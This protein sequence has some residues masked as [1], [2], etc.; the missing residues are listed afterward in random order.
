MN[1]RVLIISYFFPPD[2]GPGTQRVTKFCKYLWRFGWSPT[3]LTRMVPE[4][5]GR[6]DPEDRSL[7]R[8]I[9]SSVRVI[10]VEG[11]DDDEPDWTAHLPVL[12]SPHIM[13]WNEAAFIRARSLLEAEQFDLVLITM[14][15]FD[16]AHL[17]R[18]IQTQL[19][20]PVI[21]DLRDPWALDGWRSH[22]SS[23]HWRRDLSCMRSTLM[24]ADGVIAN[25]P[26][27]KT[28]M[29]RECREITPP[30]LYMIPNGYDE[31]D[32]SDPF[33]PVYQRDPSIFRIVHTGS[34]HSGEL[35]ARRTLKGKLRSWFECSGQLIDPSGRTPFHLLRAL[36]RLQRQGHPLAGRVRVSLIGTIDDATRRCVSESGVKHL[37]ELVDYLPHRDSVEKLQ[38]ADALFL[39]LHGLGPD[40][41][42]RIVP[43][44]TYEYLAARRPILAC[45]PPGDARELI[46]RS[47]NGWLADPCDV[48][49]I[50]HALT[51]LHEAWER[52]DLDH[53]QSPIWLRDYERKQLTARLAE[54]FDE[55]AQSQSYLREWRVAA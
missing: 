55:I 46:E 35:Y 18:R 5:R 47:G 41:R 9:P 2:G 33:L 30:R 3:V 24:H 31:S 8:D 19:G 21:Y 12:D 49:S 54:V 38:Q 11:N 16:L 22:R 45:L 15:P 48:G 40:Q 1:A 28:V 10:R 29:Q 27:A 7:Q 50:T 13:R 36:R 32:L 26:E 37:V 42:S 17:G 34:L 14:S 25:T 20:L 52:G 53:L 4:K 43:G 39:P 6:W 51:S 44:K 23:R